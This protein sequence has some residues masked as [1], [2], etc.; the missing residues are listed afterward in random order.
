MAAGGAGPI[1]AGRLARILGM[2]KVF[3]PGSAGTFC[4]S[5]LAN[6][7]I[8][9]DCSWSF[10]TRSDE[11]DTSR[12][13]RMF[14]EKESK[15]RKEL[16]RDGVSHEN[17]RLTRW[18][19]ARYAHQIW[20]DIRIPV[21]VGTLTEKHVQA[22]VN[23]FHKTYESIYTYCLQDSPVEFVTWGVTGEG[24]IPKV[25]RREQPMCREEAG[26][27]KKGE[28]LVCF[29]EEEDRIKTDIYD[30][31]KLAH[32]MKIMGP[33]IIEDPFTTIVVSP[34]FS[35]TVTAF[36]DYIMDSIS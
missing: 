31:K 35:V 30:G 25:S 7:D 18:V 10:I 29:Q 13:N 19:E 22:M 27:A 36:G 9:H 32:G 12:V 17:I 24:L 11:F 5:G 23:R 26:V 28:R 21:P 3:I 2:K 4:A 16:E 20:V 14:E 15:V 33:G 8:K 1:H 6:S 34:E